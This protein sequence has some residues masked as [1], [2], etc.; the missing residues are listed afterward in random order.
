MCSLCSNVHMCTCMG[1]NTVTILAP[2]PTLT[3]TLTHTHSHTHQCTHTLTHTHSHPHP[4]TQLSL[5]CTLLSTVDLHSTAVRPAPGA[6]GRKQSAPANRMGAIRVN[7]PLDNVHREIAI[8]KKLDHPNVVK[9]IEVLDDPREDELIMGESLA[10]FSMRCSNVFHK[11][12]KCA[13]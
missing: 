10:V 1:T 7:S 5:H 6:R 12:F 2:S 8:L 13:P 9:L 3:R 11:M 4:H